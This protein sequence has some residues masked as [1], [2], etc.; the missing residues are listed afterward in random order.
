MIHLGFLSPAL[1]IAASI[2]VLCQIFKV[3]YY[4][5]KTRSFQLR[6]LIQPA[7]MPSAHSAFVTALSTSVGVYNGVASDL[8]AL[9]FVFSVIIIYDSIRL[10]GAVQAH[11]SILRRLTRDMGRSEEIPEFVGHT[12]AEILAGV[13]IGLLWGLLGALLIF[14]R[15]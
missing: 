6:R 10:R 12:F 5:I 2:Q 9:S 7:G 4:S 14:K 8:F 3:V 11:S 13:A 15:T 1:I